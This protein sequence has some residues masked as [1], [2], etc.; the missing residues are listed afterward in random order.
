MTN[1]LVLLAPKYF[2]NNKSLSSRYY[3][4]TNISTIL[5]I[6]ACLILLLVLV[7]IRKQILAE[8]AFLAFAK[9]PP[10]SR[11]DED[12]GYWID[13]YYLIKKLNND[14]FA[15]CEPLYHQENI[16]YLICGSD[17][18]VLFDTGIG[19]NSIRNIVER[20]T[21]LPVIAIPSH[22]HFDHI[23]GCSEF[24]NVYIYPPKN[25]KKRYKNGRLKV[26]RY[27]SMGLSEDIV[28]DDIPVAR[29]L[30]N[31]E[32]IDL[33]GRVLRVIHTPGHADEQCCLLDESRSA[34][35]ASDFILKGP[36]YAFLPTSNL[37]SYLSSTENLLD[38]SEKDIVIY[39]AHRENTN[40]IPEFT[41][42]D[43]LDLRRVL[44]NI[45]SKTLTIRHLINRK[46]PVNND[47]YIVSDYYCLEILD[48]YLDKFCI[49]TKCILTK[50][51]RR[52]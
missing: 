27:E 45:C 52:I 28:I 40:T 26:S 1:P 48:L 33:G 21:T 22:L 38:R 41:Y 35:F 42:G 7:R 4:V 14:T 2:W 39:G 43:L 15:I 10:L 47:M 29:F 46:Y 34:I 44:Q 8:I 18:A 12:D 50:F 23:G 20:L 51:T 37:S 5:I 11:K 25:W 24:D 19:G 16:H 17:R 3:N 30:R 9:P 36:L 31:E 6:I 32:L 49:K 13:D